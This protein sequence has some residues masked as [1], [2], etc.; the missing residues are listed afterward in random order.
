MDKHSQ[1]G[2]K[3]G[4]DGG[5][6]G[7]TSEADIVLAKTTPSKLVSRQSA[8]ERGEGKSLELRL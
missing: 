6:G 8:G 7:E 5:T 2:E 1:E 4:W 3:M